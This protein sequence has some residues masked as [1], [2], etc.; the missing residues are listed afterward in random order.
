MAVLGSGAKGGAPSQTKELGEISKQLFEE[1][2]PVRKELLGQSLEALTT[3]GLQS[4]IPIIQEYVQQSR[5]ALSDALRQSESGLATSGLLNSSFGQRA[6]TEQRIAGEAGVGAIPSQIVQSFINQ[7]GSL[8]GNQTNIAVQGLGSAGN[9]AAGIRA[10]EIEAFSRFLTTAQN[11][12]TQLGSAGISGCYLALALYGPN[13][14]RT[15]YAWRWFNV[16]HSHTWYTKLYRRVGRSLVPI[17]W[18]FRP[19]FSILWRLGRAA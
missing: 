4:R 19:L 3:G 12:A 14:L 2:S 9:Q 1:S 10:A 5:Q 15:F 6:L 16:L 17:A 13:D 7:A 8:A 18:V 11:N